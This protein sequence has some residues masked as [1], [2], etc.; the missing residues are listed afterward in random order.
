[1]RDEDKTKRQLIDELNELR[2]RLGD[3]AYVNLHALDVTDRK[4]AEEALRLSEEKYKG[5][6]EAC[7]DAVVMSDL[8]GSVL[9]ASRQTWKLLNLAD[10][11][12]LTGRSVFDYVVEEDRQRLAA[13]F[14]RLVDAGIRHGTEYTG[15]CPDGTTIPAELSSTVIRDVAGHPKALMAVIRD[16]SGRKKAEEA[17]RQQHLQLQ[18]ICDEM[19]EGLLITD[20]ETKRFVRV[21]ASICRMLGYA[22]EELLAASIPD[23]HPAAEVADDLQR[24]QAVAEGRV[25]INEDRPVL[26]KDGSIF[27]ADITGHRIVYEG[28]SCLLALF[29]DVTERRRTQAALQRERRTLKHLLRASDHER[30]LIAYD[31]HDGLAQQ[32]AGAIMQFQ[33]YDHLKETHAGEAQ[34]AY[35]GGMTLLRQGHFEARRLISGVRPPILDEAGVLAAIAHLV[36]EHSFQGRP[37][38]IFHSN[39]KFK[40]LAGVLENVIYRIAQEGLTNASRHSKSDVVR[41]TLLQ[42]GS[43]V[44]IEIQDWGTGFNLQTVQGT[45][46]GLAGIR[47][48]ARLL[49]GRCRIRSKPSQGTRVVVEL[50]LVEKEAD[51]L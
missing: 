34:K 24:F 8:S 37:Q 45:G 38:I 41:V 9:F 29:R 30:Q 22:E 5:L 16:I 7:P 18:T 12:E 28:R 13:N 42:R 21:N 46:F 33:V 1:M 25:S 4:R 35:D 39:V 49:G 23:I 32:L 10:S 20:I 27:Y 50:P 36:N 51:E 26:R 47:E 19:V 15:L 3:A 44:R 17:L 6:V 11:E 40:R 2:Q 14:S 48:R 43:K 31:I